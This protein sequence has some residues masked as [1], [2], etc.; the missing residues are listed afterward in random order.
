MVLGCLTGHFL[1]QDLRHMQKKKKDSKA[2]RELVF[3]D[4]D[5][6]SAV[7]VTSDPVISPTVLSEPN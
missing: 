3:L 1:L 4:A 7:L 6:K 5:G 2:E